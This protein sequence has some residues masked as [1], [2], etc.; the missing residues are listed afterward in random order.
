MT[1]DYLVVDIECDSLTPSV[2]WV[3][4]T[5]NVQTN[6][7]KIWITPHETNPQAFL[8]YLCNHTLVG[9]NI[10]GFDLPVIN[11]LCNGKLK[12]SGCLDTLVLSRLA[13]SW[14]YSN[15]SLDAWGVRLGSNKIDFSDFSSL[16]QEMVDYCIQDVRLTTKIFNKLYKSYVSKGRFDKAIRLEHDSAIL[17]ETMK[18]NGFYFETTKAIDLHKEICDK[19]SELNEA[20]QK[21]FR[22][23][24]IPI[25]EITPSLTAKGNISK[26]DFRF[27]EGEPEDYGFS[28][29][30]PFSR[31]EWV[32]FNPGSPKQRI[33]ALN[34]CGWKPREKTDGHIKAEREGDKEKLEHFKTYGWKTSETNLATLPKNAPEGARK[35]VQWITLDSRRSTLEE[36]L[37]AVDKT[38]NRIR[39]NFKHIGSWT[40]R[41]SHSGPN[42][43]N[44]PS[45]A[46]PPEGREPTPVESIN[47]TYNGL[48]R[49]LWSVPPKRMLVGTDAEGI[50]LRVL[51]HY[52]GNPSYTEAIVN[53][54]KEDE[55]DIHNVNKR[56]LGLSHITRD[57]AKTFIYAWLLGAGTGKIAEI[58]RTNSH[59]ANDAMNSFLSSI[60]GLSKLKY[61]I[62]P[63][64]A[65][66]G[67]FLGLDGRVVRCDSEH[68]MLAG[69][70]QNGESVI[71]KWAN[72]IWY[73]RLKK[74][75]IWFKQVND[76]HD[77]WQTEVE[78][79]I[80]T[81]QYVAK[82]QREAIRQAGEELEVKCRLD[83]SSEI[84][85]SW[86]ETH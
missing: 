32:T 66:R 60:D 18:R 1:K 21:D 63:E 11:R 39:G 74:E 71:M 65:Q 35:L 77:E 51:A 31:F 49:S 8:D 72:R 23:K 10:L 29:D 26:K 3:A 40:H 76:V 82:I 78:D 64:D 30:A 62:I 34:A 80:E 20:I 50:Q 41:K 44:I 79:C 28:A 24:T 61:G 12:L 38:D 47:I 9:H 70:L 5:K 84:G 2:I 53:G 55:T 37:N 54:K 15:H 27:L 46:Y 67:Y 75:R 19:L 43:A 45:S 69:Y 73:K 56:A 6:E 85:Y 81:A 17:C 58:L 13:N 7:E 42:M 4:V 48:M 59:Q 16:S 36:W 86:L 68:L 25:K 33:E 52:I 83:G 14:K 22:P 57:D